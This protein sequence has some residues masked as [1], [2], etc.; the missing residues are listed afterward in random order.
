MDKEK[1][2]VGEPLRL[3]TAGTVSVKSAPAPPD[4]TSVPARVIETIKGTAKADNGEPRTVIMH[5][6]EIAS[7]RTMV[8]SEE[9][10]SATMYL[11]KRTHRSAVENKRELVKADLGKEGQKY[12][13]GLLLAEM[14]DLVADG[15]QFKDF[16]LWCEPPFDGDV[17]PYINSFRSIPDLP[18]ILSMI[19][20]SSKVES[21]TD[22]NGEALRNVVAYAVEFKQD[23]HTRVVFFTKH[24]P[25]RMFSK[26]HPLFRLQ[27][28]V[29]N[30]I[31]HDI[32]AFNNSIH[33]VFFEAE[34]MNR[35][36][37]VSVE[38]FESVFECRRR[39][40]ELSGRALSVLTSYDFVVIDSEA[41]ESISDRKR[42]LKK[43]AVLQE[44]GE[45]ATVTIEDIQHAIDAAGDKVQFKIRDGK[46][47]LYT[48]EA[49]MDFVDVLNDCIVSSIR[50]NEKILRADHTTE[51]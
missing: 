38:D 43:I 34:N 35:M 24:N 32:F 7:F 36:Y 29:F 2:V 6:D 22:F 47:M 48:E 11:I 31:D 17:V 45:F 4:K 15:K 20:K 12:F 30:K 25:A 42:Y 5:R 19:E 9:N 44:K 27:K 23:E 40:K 33:S 46:V 21:I 51:I 50:K 10:S 39:Y 41:F 3:T 49:I 13:R 26:K 28:G 8:E 16:K 1:S 37:V 14:D 18:Q